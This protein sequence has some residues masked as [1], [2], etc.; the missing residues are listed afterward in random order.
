[1]IVKELIIHLLN[2]NMDAEV[3]VIAMN[4]PQKFSIVYGD[5]EGCTKKEC[6]SVGFYVNNLNQK[7]SQY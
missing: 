3:E 7:E 4:I 5:S 6:D 1:M 2:Y